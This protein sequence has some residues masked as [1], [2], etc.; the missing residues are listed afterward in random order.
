MAAEKQSFDTKQ[1]K[2]DL[3]NQSI[4]QLYLF[5]GE[6][7]Y[8]KERYLQQMVHQIVD[9]TFREFNFQILDGKRMTVQELHDAIESYPAMAE[10]KL[11]LVKDYDWSKPSA[12]FSEYF[13]KNLPDLPPYLCCVFYQDIVPFKLDRR[14]KLHTVLLKNACITEFSTLSER[15]LIDWLQRHAKTLGKQMQKETAAYFLFFCGHSMTNLLTELEKAAAF[16]TTEEIEKQHIDAVCSRII[17]AAVFDLTDAL[18]EKNYGRSIEVFED[19]IAQKNEEVAILAAII[20]NFQ[21]IYAAKAA[22]LESIEEKQFLEMVGSHSSY[23]GR[24]LKQ[25]AKKFDMLF[26]RKSMLLL[27][28]VDAQLKSSAG[29][30]KKMIEFMLLQMAAGLGETI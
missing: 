7:S 27:S 24:K 28:Q 17:D 16:S 2:Q 14:M 9:D 25:I 20:R 19:L 8:L 18:A 30:K 29:D 23:Y 13:Q 26:L 10:R 6:E 3:K 1:L 15:D 12:E 4:G 5:F 21:R 11:V 22:T